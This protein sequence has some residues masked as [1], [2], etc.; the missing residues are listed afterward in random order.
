MKELQV[1]PPHPQPY[2][3]TTGT[4]GGKQ[5]GVVV[6]REGGGERG[7]GNSLPEEPWW[8]SE[9]DDGKNGLFSHC[10]DD[11]YGD[12]SITMYQ[13]VN[14]DVSATSVDTHSLKGDGYEKGMIVLA[15]GGHEDDATVA[16]IV[17]N[18]DCTMFDGSDTEHEEDISELAETPEEPGATRIL[19]V[20]QYPRNSGFVGQWDGGQND[21]RSSKQ[22][23]MEKPGAT[24]ILEDVQ[25]PRSTGCV[26]QSDGE[27]SALRATKV[28]K[29]DLAAKKAGL[30]HS[31]AKE[32]IMTKRG[33]DGI[34]EEL[35]NGEDMEEDE[36]NGSRGG[37]GESDDNESDNDNGTNES[38]AEGNG[39]ENDSEGGESG[40]KGEREDDE[41]F[42]QG[43]DDGEESGGEKKAEGDESG[44][45]GGGGDG[46][47]GGG[48]QGEEGGSEDDHEGEE[49]DSEDDRDGDSEDDRDGEE[50]GGEDG[51]E[52]D[53]VGIKGDDTAEEKRGEDLDEIEAEDDDKNKAHE[54]DENPGGEDDVVVVSVKKPTRMQGG[55]KKTKR[56]NTDV[57][58]VG[59][60]VGK[61]DVD[62]IDT[63]KNKYL[64]PRSLNKGDAHQKKKKTPVQDVEKADRLLAAR[65]VQSL[66]F[67]EAVGMTKRLQLSVYNE[68]FAFDVLKTDGRI[69]QFLEWKENRQNLSRGLLRYVIS[70]NQRYCCPAYHI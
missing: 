25:Y 33:D 34:E 44:G 48:E 63:S 57:E 32:D 56:T 43:E 8:L 38:G 68:K 54:S 69:S 23:P 12:E 29:F 35:S 28:G 70:D 27:V 15:D 31:T 36:D 21:L 30:G 53:D 40:G 11:T 60:A 41:D 42:G 64:S 2:S 49:G 9:P 7:G 16:T 3:N 19:E 47:G 66:H 22:K 17:V 6:G 62:E 14:S 45:G 39:G 65:D 67:D 26:Q 13:I 10:T 50:G 58:G 18:S 24:R 46:G 52:G 51:R 1:L 5:A 4:E 59:E 37:E 20:V 61:G 55:A